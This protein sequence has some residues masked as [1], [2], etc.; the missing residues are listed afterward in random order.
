MVD[1]TR[2]PRAVHPAGVL[3]GTGAVDRD[4]RAPDRR[5]PSTPRRA[6]SPKPISRSPSTRPTARKATGSGGG[7]RGPEG[8]RRPETVRRAPS[9]R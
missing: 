1:D 5:R 8:T 2:E 4:E 9:G 3:T 6:P 7:G